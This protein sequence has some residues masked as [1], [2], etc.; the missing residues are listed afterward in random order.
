MKM[1]KNNAPIKIKLRDKR[2]ILTEKIVELIPV[3][4]IKEEYLHLASNACEKCQSQAWNPPNQELLLVVNSGKL[5]AVD[6]LSSSCKN[7]QNPIELYFD[8]GSFFW[9]KYPEDKV[10]ELKV[11][12]INSIKLEEGNSRQIASNS[13]KTAESADR[14]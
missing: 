2:G 12:L 9:S 7:C 3:N 13:P 6:L 1:A 14:N 8:V 4:T 10:K 11:K 5:R